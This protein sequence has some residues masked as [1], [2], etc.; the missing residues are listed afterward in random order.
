MRNICISLGLIT[1]LAGCGSSV[2]HWTCE[3]GTYRKATVT[4]DMTIDYENRTWEE[5]NTGIREF[6]I[7]GSKLFYNFKDDYSGEERIIALDT[8]TGEYTTRGQYSTELI[9]KCN[10]R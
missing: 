2:E 4:I 10:K 1:L 7:N 5:N 9:G 8:E 6:K 3:V